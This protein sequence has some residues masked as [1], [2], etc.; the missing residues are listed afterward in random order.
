MSIP[1]LR[2]SSAAR[3]AAAVALLSLLGACGGSGSGGPDTAD[4]QQKLLDHINIVDSGVA[5]ITEF[6]ETSRKVEKVG[7][8]EGCTVQ[9]AGQI[10]YTRDGQLSV[11]PHKQGD[12]VP[13]DATIEYAREGSTW[14][15]ITMG[16]YER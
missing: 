4:V 9:F 12:V 13:F 2:L 15:Q 7:D 11:K 3:R 14:K 8:M 5:R 1:S 6:K 16:F 10:Q